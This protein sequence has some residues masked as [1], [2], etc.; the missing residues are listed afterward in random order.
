MVCNSSRSCASWRASASILA[1][2]DVMT[3][4]RSAIVRSCSAMRISSASMRETGSGED[5]FKV[6]PTHLG[7]HP[8]D[9]VL[10]VCHDLADVHGRE[11][12]IAFQHPAIDDYGVD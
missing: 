3:S 8:V 9:R 5:S 1:H 2:C 10:G 11:P 6:S 4:F 7:A 12:A